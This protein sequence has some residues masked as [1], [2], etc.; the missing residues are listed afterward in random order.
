MRR[1]EDF[2]GIKEW[3]IVD[4]QRPAFCPGAPAFILIAAVVGQEQGDQHLH[5]PQ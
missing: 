2:Q 3:T 5:G 1:L 4:P